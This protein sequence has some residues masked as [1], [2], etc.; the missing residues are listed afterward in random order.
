MEAEKSGTLKIF[1]VFGKLIYKEVIIGNNNEQNRNV[2]L[3]EFA[4]GVYI[5]H[6]LSGEDVS[7]TRFIKNSN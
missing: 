2:N 5:V 3:N 1:D 6:L 7:S 4:I